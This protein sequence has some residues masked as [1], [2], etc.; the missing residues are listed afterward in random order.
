VTLVAFVAV[1]LNVDDE[2]ELI[3]A[4]FAV[5]LTVGAVAFTVT[6]ADAVAVP[7]APLAVA[8]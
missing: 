3:E 6:V 8:V 2:P 7:P 1:T 5:M 4:G